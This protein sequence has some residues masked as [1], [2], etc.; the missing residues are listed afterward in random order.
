MR[1]MVRRGWRGGIGLSQA[2]VEEVV[3]H[4]AQETFSRAAISMPGEIDRATGSIEFST[5]DEQRIW[6]R[7]GML[8]HGPTI[9]YL[10]HN[11]LYDRGAVYAGAYGGRIK[12]LRRRP[13]VVGSID[14]VVE[15]Q[16]CSGGGGERFFGHW[17]CD[18]LSSELLA[19]DRGLHP[20]VGR[21]PVY[22]HEPGYRALAD[23]HAW[24]I[25][26]AIVDKLWMIDDRGY[27]AGRVERFRRLRSRIGAGRSPGGDIVYIGRGVT[28]AARH[29]I[30]D[31]DVR[32]V[33]AQ[34]GFVI[35]DP[36][37][38]QPH[39]IVRSLS[40]AS[41]VVSVEGSALCHA[42]VAAPAS[43]GIVAIQPPNRLN[44][45]NKIVADL[46]GMRFG[47]VVAE[48]HGQAFSVD[49]TRLMKTIDLV[50]QRL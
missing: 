29:L 33:F 18:N 24:S 38:L 50:A 2:A 1:S 14:H 22:D 16:M 30:N 41:V 48:P 10:L 42:L 8:P 45:F 12:S 46:L 3:L 21:W 25:D 36:E 23:L 17:L 44:L 20:L 5:L 37:Q 49:I 32:E 47:Y 11:A 7:E 15:G 6:D 39:E 31:A 9:S 40:R 27:N 43:A 28:G 35:V 26:C 13:I 34:R 19:A 4:P